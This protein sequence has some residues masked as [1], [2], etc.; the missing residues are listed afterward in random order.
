M[1]GAQPAKKLSTPLASDDIQIDDFDAVEKAAAE[2]EH[3]IAVNDKRQQ[4]DNDRKLAE[5]MQRQ[6][7]GRTARLGGSSFSSHTPQSPSGFTARSPTTTT[8]SSGNFVESHDARDRFSRNKGISSDQYFGMVSTPP[9]F[10]FGA[11][12]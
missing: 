10:L 1:Q 11:L 6:E 12:L 8:G 3:A 2:A 5:A 7:S 9:A 4:E